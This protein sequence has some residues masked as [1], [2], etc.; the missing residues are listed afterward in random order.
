MKKFLKHNVLTITALLLA[1]SFWFFDSLVHFFIY[2]EPNFEF[3]PAEFNDL[4][5]RSSIVVLM[6]LFGIFADYF[7]NNISSR[8]KLLELTCVY[9]D[10]LHSNLDVLSNQLD[11]MK[12]FSMEARQSK[13]FDAEIIELF[14]N[15]IEEITGLVESLSRVTDVTDSTIKEQLHEYDSQEYSHRYP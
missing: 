7:K 14:D 5:M 15:S 2:G 12:L 3:V 11:Q 4:W 9:N 13:D 8:E 6:V 10:L 1:F